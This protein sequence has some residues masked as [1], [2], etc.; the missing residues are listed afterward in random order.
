MNLIDL[1]DPN[2]EGYQA[3]TYTTMRESFH[4][5]CEDSA[6]VVAPYID[7]CPDETDIEGVSILN[8]T[9]GFNRALREGF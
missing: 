7:L 9:Q 1:F 8:F 3:R 2:H 4:G 5:P 6:E